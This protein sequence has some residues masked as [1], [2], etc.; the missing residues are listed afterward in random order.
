MRY[1]QP[2]FLTG[3][4][5]NNFLRLS[6]YKKNPFEVFHFICF[7]YIIISGETRSYQGDIFQNSFVYHTQIA[8]MGRRA[9]N[10]AFKFYDMTNLSKYSFAQF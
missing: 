1:P 10:A 4:E 8:V 6:I 2:T 7:S 9:Q 5:K 3:R